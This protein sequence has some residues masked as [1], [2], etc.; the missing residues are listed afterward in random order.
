MNNDEI[1]INRCL[2]LARYAERQTSPSPLVGAVV[3]HNGKI[4]GEGYGRCG[5]P[6][7]EQKAIA[8]VSDKSLLRHST[9]YVNIEPSDPQ[10]IIKSGIPRVVV[11]MLDVDPKTNGKG[12]GLLR[13]AGI[14]VTEGVLA[15]E[16]HRLNRRFIAFTKR[17]CPYIILKWAQTADGFID[18]VRESPE[19]PPLKI[20]NTITKTLNHQIRTREAAIM[21]GTRTVFLDNPHL[22]VS[23][24]TGKNPIRIFIDRNLRI[25]R[26]YR[27]F[28]GTAKTIVFN[29]IKDETHLNIV[30]VRLDF[31][32]DIIPQMLDF[33]YRQGVVSVIVEGGR[34]LLQSFIDMGVW[35]EAI[36]EESQQRV[37]TGVNA[38]VLTNNI[39]LKEEYLSKNRCTTYTNSVI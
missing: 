11:G 16:C 34:Q 37:G 21:V 22:T 13:Q 10:S 25:H 32:R 3:V 8:A 20:S 29:D 19:L 35:D 23:K 39:A 14:D 24:W 30:F 9:L 18:I 7:A 6:H 33:L 15:E 27:V 1:H 36:V 4:I 12:I 17:H 5:E 2:T 31:G 26:N 28:D 38:P